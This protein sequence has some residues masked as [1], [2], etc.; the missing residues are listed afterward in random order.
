MVTASLYASRAL[1]CFSDVEVLPRSLASAIC[2]SICPTTTL[3]NY[4]TSTHEETLLVKQ[5]NGLGK[6]TINRPNALNAKNCGALESLT[7][8]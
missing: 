7:I 5:E 1:R 4:G 6:I 8:M 3:R 2:Q